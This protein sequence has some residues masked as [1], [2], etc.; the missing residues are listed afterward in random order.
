MK[1]LILITLVFC[2]FGALAISIG[3]ESRKQKCFYVEVEES[4]TLTISYVVSGL[5]EDQL[6]MI[7]LKNLFLFKAFKLSRYR[8]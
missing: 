4:R 8:N 1:T 5:G 2:Q 7:V 6:E 3:L